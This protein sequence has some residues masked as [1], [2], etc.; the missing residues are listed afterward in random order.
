MINMSKSLRSLGAGAVLSLAALATS[1]AFAAPV[2]T[3]NPNSNGFATAGTIFNADAMNGFSSARIQ[4][5]GSGTTYTGDGYINFNGFALNSNNVST[6]ASRINFDYG[7]YATFH[8]TFVCSALLAPGVTCAVSSISL[9]LFGDPGNDNTYNT[10][11][12]TANGT[13]TTNGAQILLAT[14]DTVI[15]GQAGIDA[16]GGAFQNI[17]TNFAL[18][19][20][21]SAYFVSPVPFYSFAFS[22][23]NNTS[24]GLACN[25]AGCVG[26]T[27]VAITQESG[28]TDFNAVPEPGPI[29][30]IGVGLLG[31]V[32]MIRRKRA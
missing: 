11:S 1:S 30:L 23:F 25:T 14:V 27:V 15:S 24:Q 18:T 26:A 2:F 20:A 3:V 32:G 13:V 12:L 9:S 29:S 10:A 31:L 4:Y 22:A 19:S 7:L 5:T 21:G 16:L 6:V 28:I 17:N 8:Q